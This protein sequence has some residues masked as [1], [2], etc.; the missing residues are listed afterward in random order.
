MSFENPLMYIVHTEIQFNKFFKLVG[1]SKSRLIS[2][3]YNLLKRILNS[4]KCEDLSTI[5]Y[6]L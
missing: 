2:L 5:W 1:M 3:C 4:T 6:V